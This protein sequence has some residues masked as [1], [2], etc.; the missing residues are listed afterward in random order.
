MSYY[1]TGDLKN[2]LIN[3]DKAIILAGNDPELKI[4]YNQVKA[5]LTAQVQQ[6]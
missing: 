6:Q 1:A 4:Q 5:K 3:L 2:A